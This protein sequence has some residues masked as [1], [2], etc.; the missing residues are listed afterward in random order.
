M[1]FFK[2]P[3]IKLSTKIIKRPNI[4]GNSKPLYLRF[5]KYSISYFYQ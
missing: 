3:A 4:F 5:I 1:Q 2:Y